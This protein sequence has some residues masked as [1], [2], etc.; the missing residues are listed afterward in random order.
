MYYWSSRG[1]TDDGRLKPDLVGP[2]DGF[3]HVFHKKP[4]TPLPVGQIIGISN[5]A[6]LRWQR[7]LLRV[8]QPNATVSW[9]LQIDQHPK[10]R[11]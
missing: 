11:W 5:T 1:P 3:A 10:E 7:Q 4:R 9:M 8:L 2:G 6:V